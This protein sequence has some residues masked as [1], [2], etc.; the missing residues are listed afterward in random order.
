MY[1]LLHI[2][3][4]KNSITLSFFRWR[5]NAHVDVITCHT[6]SSYALVL[7]DDCINKIIQNQRMEN[8]FFYYY[9]YVDF[10]NK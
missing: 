4:N 5:N 8:T 1:K 6:T 9:K 7:N 2:C 10:S 3:E